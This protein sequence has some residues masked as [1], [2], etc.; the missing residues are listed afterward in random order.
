MKIAVAPTVIALDLIMFHKLPQPKIVASVLVVCLGIAVATVTDHQMV[1]PRRFFWACILLLVARLSVQVWQHKFVT[2]VQMV[3]LGTGVAIVTYHCMV[4]VPGFGVT[5]SVLADLT[6]QAKEKG[7]H[8][9]PR[10]R[11]LSLE[12]VGWEFKVGDVRMMAWSPVAPWSLHLTKRVPCT[13]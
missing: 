5:S 7:S 12:S 11:V 2:S 4:C 13:S 3:C 8:S 1:C 9:F 10:R 6:C